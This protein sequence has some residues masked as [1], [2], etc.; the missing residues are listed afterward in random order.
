MSVG[1]SI[2][3]FLE[4]ITR[5]QITGT[6]ALMHVVNCI[7]DELD[8]GTARALIVSL[9][10]RGAISDMTAGIMLAACS[11][12]A[13]KALPSE[14]RDMARAGILKQMLIRCTVSQ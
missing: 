9:S 2:S 14:Y 13:L 5:V 6:S 8:S 3:P 10:D 4:K 1:T 7:G 11:D 12:S